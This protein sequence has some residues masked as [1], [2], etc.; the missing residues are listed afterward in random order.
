MKKVALSLLAL[1]LVGGFAF[2]DATADVVKNPVTATFDVNASVGL[3]TDLD[4]QVHGFKYGN[5]LALTLW[6]LNGTSEKTGDGDVHGYIQLKDVKYGF[7]DAGTLNT[8][9]TG[10]IA[11]GDLNA[12]IVAGDFYIALSGGRAKTASVGY[13]IDG[14]DDNGGASIVSND[15][16][17]R[18]NDKYGATAAAANEWQTGTL[19]AYDLVGGAG[20]E[21]GYTI[22]SM[23]KL[24]GVVASQSD[25]SVA[26]QSDYDISAALALL[27]V[28]KLTLEGK[29]YQ[30]AASVMTAAGATVAYDLGM[31]APFGDV[32]YS[33]TKSTYVSDFGAKLPLADGLK[34]VVVG[35]YASTGVFDLTTTV[36][37]AQDK[38]AGPLSADVGLRLQDVTKAVATFA[39]TEIFAKVGVKLTDTLSAGATVDTY[40]VS[41]SDMALFAKAK[42]EYSGISLTTV[43]VYWDSSDINGKVTGTSK[44]GQ[45][46]LKAKI[47]Y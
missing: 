43:G 20:V 34:A 21:V 27:A 17:Y 25:W 2:A 32:N 8:T 28:D 29:Y 41:T 16:Y 36:N 26:K 42:L 18:Y 30:D 23:V 35:K 40:S 31:V 5:S 45:V 33:I 9:N 44:L 6:F 46:Q 11:F 13:G 47:V 19:A 4:T 14:D 38:L 1:A 10:T 22:P 12:K 39:T 7:D 37:V 3:G 24:T 15:V